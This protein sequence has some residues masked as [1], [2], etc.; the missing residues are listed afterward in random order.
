MDYKSTFCFKQYKSIASYSIVDIYLN[1][2]Q[3]LLV[4][5]YGL[6]VILIAFLIAEPSPVKFTVLTTGF[7]GAAKFCA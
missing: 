2:E 1:I 6:T 3:L 7:A 5:S 4:K